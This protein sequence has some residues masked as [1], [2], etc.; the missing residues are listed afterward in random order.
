M[1][2]HFAQY[3]K[4]RR[5]LPGIVFSLVCVLNASAADNGSPALVELVQRHA[6]AQRDFDQAT[7]QAV[8]ADNYV[9][10]SPAGEVDSREKM[11]SFYAPDQ[12]RAAPQLTVTEPL[13][14]V[15]GDTAVVLARLNY[16]MGADAQARTFAMRASYVAQLK[17][18]K[19]KLVSAQYTGIRPG[20][21]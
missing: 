18:G 10:V 13:V 5:L 2:K 15:L 9:E 3:A 7:L 12:K 6:E 17:E 19:W 21:K 8:T 16:T 14:R 1:L 4:P 11:L 20:K